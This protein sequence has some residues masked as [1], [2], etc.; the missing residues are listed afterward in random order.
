MTDVVLVHSAGHLPDVW[1]GL[2]RALPAGWKPW[3]PN[4]S[5]TTLEQYLDKQELRRVVLVGHGTGA[6]AAARLAQEQPQRVT[7]VLQLVPEAPRV[8]PRFLRRKQEQAL[9][10]PVPTRRVTLSPADAAA[11]VAELQELVG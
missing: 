3:L 6:V 2:V 9:E 4:L 7:H 1:T 11:V 8:L 10:T 5:V